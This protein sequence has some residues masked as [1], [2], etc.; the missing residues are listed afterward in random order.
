MLVVDFHTH[1]F[2]D[3]LAERA[4]PQLEQEGGVKA[5]LDGKVSSLLRSMDDAG[6]RASVV[7]S[8]ATKP[9]QFR[10]ILEWSRAIASERIVPFP[11]LHP[12][13]PA[14]ADQVAAI[15]DAGFLGVKLHPYYQGYLLDEARLDPVYAAL[16]RHELLL[17]SHC[18][19]DIAFPRE[20]RCDPA[21]IR[22]V[23]ERFPQLKFVAAHLGAWED[24][25]EVER[26]LLGQPVLMDLS[27]TIEWIG[28]DRAKEF[29]QRHPQD[30][31]L[32]GTDSPWISQ[33]AALELVRKMELEPAREQA[34]L[35]GNAARLLG[36]PQ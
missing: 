20:R 10:P 17:L 5:V 7:A 16:E 24:W 9:T 29:L 26:L 13:D 11:S 33:R 14:A 22:R 31:L 3:S 8:I 2:P 6:I 36:L 27:T 35:G 19:F 30:Y 25:D 15:A 23:L 1:A 4:I 34:L 32:F 18:G 12:D 21:R 28:F